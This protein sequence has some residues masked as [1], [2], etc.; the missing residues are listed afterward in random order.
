M[1]FEEFLEKAR[2]IKEQYAQLNIVKGEQRWGYVNRTEAL[3]GDV[4]DLMKMVMA[5]AG[6][7]EFPDL[8]KNLRHE[9]VDCLWAIF[10]ISDELGIRLENE[11]TPWLAEMQDKIIKEKQ[12]TSK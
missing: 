2:N 3:V 7:R 4:G 1:N 9:L 12:K 10:V 11:V 5:K 6:Y 8:E